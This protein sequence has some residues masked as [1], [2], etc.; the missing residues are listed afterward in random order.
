MLLVEWERVVQDYKHLHPT[1]YCAVCSTIKCSPDVAYDVACAFYASDS[2]DHVPGVDGILRHDVLLHWLHR[3][4]L[5]FTDAVAG[6]EKA[7]WDAKQQA[8]H[9]LEDRLLKR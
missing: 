6:I 9:K 5:Q 7:A 2:L 8:L 4:S 3:N 1:T